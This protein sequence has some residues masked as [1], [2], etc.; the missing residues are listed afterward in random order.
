MSGPTT[1]VLA[2]LELLQA[3]GRINGAELAK[4]LGVDRRTVR[5]YITVLED[6]GIPVTTEQGRFGG[7]MLVA[8]FKLPPMMFTEEEILAVSL[9]LMAVSQLGLGEATPA[10]AGV[11]AKLERVMPD[12]LKQR[13]RAVG[14]TTRLVLPRAELAYDDRSLLTLTRAAQTGRRVSLCYHSPRGEIIERVVDPYGLVFRYSRWY[15]SGYCHLRQDLRSFRLDRISRVKL[16]DTSFD[17][18]AQF[19][20]AEH[21]DQSFQQL[22]RA[23]KVTVLLQADMDTVA[24]VLGFHPQ[25]V[26]IFESQ[27]GGLLMHTHTDS[28]EWFSRWLV[29]LPFPFRVEAPQ[30]LKQAVRERGERIMAATL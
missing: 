27:D 20:V 22:E 30:S 25:S 17:R 14:E 15:M 2:L 4:R 12:K 23:H 7:Y 26:D 28:I 11:Q 3:H 21:L 5:R 16:L 6:L 24:Q 13:V 29:Q 19:D 8:G 1:R 10:I 9:G 18:P